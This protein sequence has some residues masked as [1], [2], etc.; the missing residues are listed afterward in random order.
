MNNITQLNKKNLG[1]VFTP[2]FIVKKMIKLI[3]IQ[4]PKRILEPSSGTG[5]FYY[6]LKEKQQFGNYCNWKR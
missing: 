1:Q 5:N 4:N 3:S 6:K 2:E